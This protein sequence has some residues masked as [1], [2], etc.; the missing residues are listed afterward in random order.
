MRLTLITIGKP[1]SKATRA[2]IKEY[3][4]RLSRYGRFEHVIVS[5][6][7]KG[8]VAQIRKQQSDALLQAVPARA[9]IIVLDERGETWTSEALAEH[10]A[11]DA[12]HGHSHWALLIGGSDGHDPS[13]REHADKLWSLSKL[14][15]P[16]D[17]AAILVTE[18]LYRAMT[19][20]N[21]EPYHRGG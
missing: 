1:R 4:E 10:M 18:Q 20:Q 14:T 7:Q 17:L 15:L 12:L 2:L 5:D 21:G 11:N 19:I 9:K 8:D 16:H 3:G 13:L 6:R